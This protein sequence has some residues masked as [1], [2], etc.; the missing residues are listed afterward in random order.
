MNNGQD[1]PLQLWR[2]WSPPDFLND[3]I[4]RLAIARGDGTSIAVY[5]LVLNA[6]YWAGGTLPADI[7]QLAAVLGARKTWV[8]RGLT[9]WLDSGKLQV[10][11]G[12]IFH[13]RTRAEAQKDLALRR[14]ASISGAT[15]NR[16]RWQRRVP[17]QVPDR[18]PDRDGDGVP[19]ATPIAVQNIS[20]L[21]PDRY[22]S[23][24]PTPTPTPDGR[25]E[26]NRPAVPSEIATAIEDVAVELAST[27][28]TPAAEWI[29]RASAI[30]ADAVHGAVTPFDDPRRPGISEAWAVATLGRLRGFLLEARRGVPL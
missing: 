9:L 26:R 1:Y 8:E 28:K 17:D 20:V 5:A 18:V 27:S 22:P 24:T 23:P 29:R 11:D 3:E 4:V 19:N 10:E 21:S 15:G 13:R 30:P 14:A 12:R 25:T 16:K 2:T 7:E 6:S